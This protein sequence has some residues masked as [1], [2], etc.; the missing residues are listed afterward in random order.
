MRLKVT[1]CKTTQVNFEMLLTYCSCHSDTVYCFHDVT[2]SWHR[3]TAFHLDENRHILISRKISWRAYWRTR[4]KHT[5]TWT[6]RKNMSWLYAVVCY[7]CFCALVSAHA[8]CTHSVPHCVC[9]CHNWICVRVCMPAALISLP[10]AA[11]IWTAALIRFE[12]DSITQ[13]PLLLLWT[14][15]PKDR[16]RKGKREIPFQLFWM[17]WAALP[18][19]R[20]SVVCHLPTAEL[21]KTVHICY[22]VSRNLSCSVCYRP[23]EKKQVHSKD[24]GESWKP[25]IC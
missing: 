23:L 22:M 19:E 13:A 8:G 5:Y 21:Y 18:A 15:S 20:G 12:S 2:S 3:E 9:V 10:L 14:N 11:L 4:P 17:L 25:A 1:K 6:C 16:E 7:V 24:V